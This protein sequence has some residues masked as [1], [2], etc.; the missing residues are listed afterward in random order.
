MNYTAQE[1]YDWHVALRNSDYTKAEMI[2][3]FRYSLD[4][5]MKKYLRHNFRVKFM[6]LALRLITHDD[7]GSLW[8]KM[9][10]SLEQVRFLL[11]AEAENAEIDVGQHGRWLDSVMEYIN[12]LG[13]ELPVPPEDF[14][15][16][17]DTP[18]K[19]VI[20]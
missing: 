16:L 19:V 11:H 5:F 12:T 9:I 6:Y 15:P 4:Y 8:T 1:L 13:D 18:P 2:R 10:H 3:H 20:T 14:N 7:F 17:T